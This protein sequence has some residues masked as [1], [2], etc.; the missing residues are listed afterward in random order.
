[1]KPRARAFLEKREGYERFRAGAPVLIVPS[2]RE[3]EPLDGHNFAVNA[4]AP[5]FD[6]FRRNHARSPR[7]AHAQI[8]F[9][10]RDREV[11]RRVE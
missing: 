3:G 5:V 6:A 4:A 7:A 2:V 8:A 10:V 11:V 1:M 9:A